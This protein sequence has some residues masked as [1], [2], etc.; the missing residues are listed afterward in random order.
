MLFKTYLAQRKSY[1][2]YQDHDVDEGT[3][4]QLKY[5]M[6]QL[7]DTF[8]REWFVLSFFQNGKEIVDKLVGKAGY[9]GVMI[10][11]PHYVGFSVKSDSHEAY[12]W[13]AYALAALEKKAFELDIESCWVSLQSASEELRG[14]LTEAPE[15][16]TQVLLAIGYGKDHLPYRPNETANRLPL[17]ELVFDEDLK[18]PFDLEKLASWGIEDLFYYV[19]NAPSTYNRQPWRFVIREGK[20]WLAMES[21]KEEN[22][23]FDAGIVMFLF[24]GLAADDNYVGKWKLE[25]IHEEHGAHFIATYHL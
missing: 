8:G 15:E 2:T 5:Y 25:P 18:H 24:E 9:H 19:R 16:V 13:G 1:R 10:E 11:S 12:L 7:N 4:N 22:E 3:L 6:E 20:V 14:S 21:F 23:Y 17:N